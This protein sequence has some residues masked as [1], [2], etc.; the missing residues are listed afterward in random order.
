MSY[1]VIDVEADGPIPGEYSMIS[2]GAIIVRHDLSNIEDRFYGQCKPISEKWNPDA[3][4][5]SG[6]SRVECLTFPDPV[7]TMNNFVNW[8]VERSN[9]RPIFFADN[10]GF[11]W[12]FM[13]YY[14]HRFTNKNPFGWSSR[15][16]NDLWHGLKRD[17]FSSF[18]HL[19]K[20]PHDHNPVNDA[21]GNAEVLI[22]MQKMGLNLKFV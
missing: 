19:R 8:V 9:G 6:H 15:N 20:T 11:D 10:N 3:L 21:I 14:M 5:I 12:M 13:C 16:I 2:F 17:M 1:F 7:E 18:K 22:A 4:S